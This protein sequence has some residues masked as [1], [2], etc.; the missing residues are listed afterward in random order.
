MPIKCSLQDVIFFRPKC[1][2]VGSKRISVKTIQS[3]A[4]ISN[5]IVLGEGLY[6]IHYNEYTQYHYQ[7]KWHCVIEFAVQQL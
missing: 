1:I 3:K 4:T 2:K 6:L 5:L 7:N